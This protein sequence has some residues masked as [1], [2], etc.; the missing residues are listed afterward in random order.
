MRTEQDGD[1][2]RQ[3][4]ARRARIP[5]S[6][7]RLEWEAQPRDAIIQ[8]VLADYLDKI[9]R[10]VR[11][12][13]IEVYQDGEWFYVAD[14]FHRTEATIRSEHTE[15]D[16]TVRPG[17]L[18]AAIVASCAANQRNGAHRTNADKQRALERMLR[19]YGDDPAW[20]D[21]R[22]GRHCGVDHKTVGALRP[23]T[24]PPAAEVAAES[25]DHLHGE[26]P[27]TSQNGHAPEETSDLATTTNAPATPGP[28][29]PAGRPRAPRLRRGNG[30]GRQPGQRF[31]EETR[32][33]G[34]LFVK[35]ADHTRPGHVPTWPPGVRAANAQAL[36]DLVTLAQKW[37]LVIEQQEGAG[38]G[39]TDQ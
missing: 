11:F 31:G 22:I 35:L 29:V 27:T 2:S 15:I 38:N 18:A 12:P 6:R 5:L 28:R 17:G 7:I 25:D 16:A 34:G 3:T 10:G 24:V 23:T 26:F 36:R 13:A 19:Y 20:T 14:G 32:R 4:D 9:R 37:L 1:Q 30:N 39:A 33:I 21:R 8:E